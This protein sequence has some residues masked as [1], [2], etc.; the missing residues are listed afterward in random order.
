MTYK[1]LMVWVDEMGDNEEFNF[2]YNGEGYRLS[3]SQYGEGSKYYS[4]GKLI[5]GRN[6]ILQTMNVDKITKNNI[7]LYSYDMMS[8][9]TSYRMA[10]SE[11]E[12]A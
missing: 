5:P 1:D 3:C 8:Q 10:I 4:V 2:T 6:F 7:C 9:R 11:I 12:L